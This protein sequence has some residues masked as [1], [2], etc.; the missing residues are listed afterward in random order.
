MA[1]L[2]KQSGYLHHFSVRAE[3][4]RRADRFLK[5]VCAQLIAA[6]G[7][8]YRSLP[9]ESQTDST[10]LSRLLG[11]AAARL[12]RGE[13]ILVLVDAL[14]EADAPVDKGAN[15]LYLPVTV[16]ERVY[17]VMTARQQNLDLRIDCEFGQM[18]I[19]EGSAEHLG[20]IR[21]YLASK[22]ESQKLRE[23]RSR[24]GLTLPQFLARL[25]E[26][27]QG[28]FMYLRY[29]LPE[30]ERGAY[31]NLDIRELPVGLANYYEDHWGR[32]RETDREAWFE[33]KLPVIAA[34]TVSERPVSVDLLAKLAQVDRR[35]R[36][37]AVID[38]LRQF[39]NEEW[40]Q[41]SEGLTKRYRW[42][43]TSFSDFIAAKD[44]VM[45]ERLDLAKAA[46]RI[47]S[48]Y[49]DSLYGAP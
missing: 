25:E 31:E 30:M 22:A 29:V 7:L 14:D 16:P 36:V 10:F 17:I 47:G 37:Q 40:V 18:E 38:D 13:K 12:R 19:A 26:K 45:A 4:V 21:S 28:N 34:L 48:R 9:A 15:L 44:Q 23:Y 5:N 11:E 27:S 2:V 35:A 42:Y 20:D 33:Y 46:R 3:G 39:L 41:D 1:Q 24:S 32:L 49:W 43:H 8:P 6:C